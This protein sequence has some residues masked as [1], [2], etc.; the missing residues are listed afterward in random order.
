MA[1][2]L[3]AIRRKVLELNGQRR[4]SNIQLWKPGA[5]EYKIR[6]LPWKNAVDGNPFIERWFYYIGDNK[7]VLTLKQFG[8]YDP[9]D[10]FCHKL[11]KSGKPDERVLAKKIMPK[12]RAYAPVIVRGEEDKG[13]Q[14]WS[15][16]K[17]VYQRLLGFF[18]EEE[19][20]NILD[21][22]EGF[23]L[24]VKI[25]QAPGKQ[26]MDTT[27]DAAR[28]A[29]KLHEDPEKVKAWLESVPNIDDMYQR[30][31]AKEV[32]DVL[33]SWLNSP[34]ASKN[35]SD[36]SARGSAASTNSELDKLAEDVATVTKPAE[37]QAETSAWAA[38]TTSEEK[39]VEKPKRAKKSAA[40]KVDEEPAGK[41]Q[42]LDEAFDDLLGD[43]A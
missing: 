4:N 18:I 5:G 39:P 31:T 34:E 42:S 35:D 2:D 3:D 17:M 12:M 37:K 43:D 9:I 27:V 40:E 7:G 8:Q 25:Q 41:K 24:K 15:F 32:E 23:D 28:K 14:V 38:A 19:V 22:N 29:T 1:I 10:E 33:N 26:F 16:G 30:K 6:A 36:G 11:F 21:P 20:G 13:V